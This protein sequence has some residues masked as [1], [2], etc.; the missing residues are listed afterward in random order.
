MEVGEAIKTLSAVDSADIS[1]VDAA[2]QAGKNF[3]AGAEDYAHQA[4]DKLDQVRKIIDKAVDKARELSDVKN[5]PIVKAATRLSYSC[6]KLAIRVKKDQPKV[7]E[8]VTAITMP[9]VLLA[10]E[11]YGDSSRAED[12]KKLNSIPNP[13]MVPAGTKLKVYAR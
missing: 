13:F 8:Y 5:Y 12:I 1:E 7:T 10:Q 4:E 11:L 3:T 2:I 9:L 6:Q